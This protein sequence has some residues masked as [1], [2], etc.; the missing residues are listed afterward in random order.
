M[1]EWSADNGRTWQVIWVAATSPVAAYLR[2]GTNPYAD[3][4]GNVY[5]T[6]AQ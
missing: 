4:T 6:V 3:G 2:Q 5:R 1:V